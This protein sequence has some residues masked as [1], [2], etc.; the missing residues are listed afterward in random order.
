MKKKANFK[1][2]INREKP[3]FANYWAQINRT[4][5]QISGKNKICCLVLRKKKFDAFCLITNLILSFQK[6]PEEEEEKPQI[7]F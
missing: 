2:Q 1:A 6:P 3:Q 4:E 5:L 7:L